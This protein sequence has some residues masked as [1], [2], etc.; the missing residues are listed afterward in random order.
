MHSHTHRLQSLS[1]CTPLAAPALGAR[2]SR[3]RCYGTQRVYC[4]SQT[5]DVALLERP[6]MK[7][8]QELPRPGSDSSRPA[9]WLEAKQ[10][11][12]S[13]HNQVLNCLVHDGGAGIWHLLLPRMALSLR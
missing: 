13:Q 5:P 10:G 7:K 1:A 12:I 8:S 11:D 2:L 6:G 4:A 9:E 3:Q